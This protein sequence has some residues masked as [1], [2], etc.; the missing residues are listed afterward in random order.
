MSFSAP[1]RMVKL[2][3]GIQKAKFFQGLRIRIHFIFP[4]LQAPYPCEWGGFLVQAHQRGGALLDRHG[5]LA[6]FDL[7]V[8]DVRDVLVDGTAVDLHNKN[9]RLISQD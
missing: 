9:L 4:N 6:E 5:K 1:A 8:R 2:V 3:P 7:H